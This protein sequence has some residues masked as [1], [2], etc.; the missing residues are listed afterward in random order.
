[1]QPGRRVVARAGGRARRAPR[2]DRRR[3]PCRVRSTPWRGSILSRCSRRVG[4]ERLRPTRAAAPAARSR[5]AAEPV[6]GLPRLG[7][8]PRL[9]EL[10]RSLRRAGAALPPLR[11]CR[12]PRRSS[13][14]RRLP[15]DAAAF[16]RRPRR[17][18]LPAAVG[19][20]GDRVQVPWRARSRCRASPTPSS[21]PSDRR[22]GAAGPTLA[23]AGAARRGAAGASAATTR[24]GSWRAASRAGSSSPPSRE[25]LLRL[26]DT[27]HQL[28]LPLAERAGNVRGAFAVEPRRARR[29]ARPPRRRRRRRHDHRQHRRRDRRAC[30]KQAGAA[31]VEIWV[32]RAHAAAGRR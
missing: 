28:A 31:T 32:A 2:R 1:M 7:P 19:P 8:R 4:R 14:L 20:A 17:G 21:A 30:C 6:R 5:C 27:A 3:A 15:D 26:R 29:A 23:A 25:L 16:R 9:R 10:P 18:R 11:A 12:W 22:A 13:R 24:R